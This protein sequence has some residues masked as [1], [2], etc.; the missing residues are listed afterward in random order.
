MNVNK[1]IV[2]GGVTRNPEVRVTTKGIPVASF[3]IA[4]NRKIGND[5]TTEFHNIVAF[6]KLAESVEKYL[7]TGMTAFVEG[8]LQTRQ[9]EANGHK[10]YRTEVIA[11][12][13]RWIYQDKEEEKTV[14]LDG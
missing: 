4:T 3:G 8:H 5:K 11:E 2:I 10:N 9:W 6:G 7:K 12:S 13:V 14:Q 1:A